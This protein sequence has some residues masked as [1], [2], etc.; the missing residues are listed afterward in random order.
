MTDI[1]KTLEE[2]IAFFDAHPEKAQVVKT[3]TARIVNGLACEVESDDWRFTVDMPKGMGGG[4]SAPD[5]G[6]F[7][8][9]TLASCLAIGYGI[10][11]AR[12]DIPVEAIEVEVAADTD[13]RGILGSVEGLPPGNSRFSYRVK[14]TSEA[15]EAAIRE[16]VERADSLSPWLYNF[17]HPFQIERDIAIIRK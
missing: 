12:M 9:G 2:R 11:F 17:S 10:W 5:P 6:V 14:I 15:P 1:K 16:A 3:T 4:Q 13:G 8:R 7:G